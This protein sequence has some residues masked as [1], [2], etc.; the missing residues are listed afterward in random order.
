[1]LPEVAARKPPEYTLV[2]DGRSVVVSGQV[3][4]KPIR[5][6][7]IV[8]LAI[9]EG[10]RGLVLEGAARVFSQLSP[11]DW[12]EAHG[13]VSQRAGLPVIAVA[14]I[15]TVSSG[16][17]PYP[18]PLNPADVQN[19]DRL[20][21]LVVT[22]GQVIEIGSNFGGAYL[23]MGNYPNTLKVF[24]PNPPDVRQAFAGYAVGDTVRV[25]GIAYQYCPIPPHVD[26]FELLI[27][28]THDV[29]RVSG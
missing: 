24:L 1:T 29:A 13:R 7:E 18:L 14:K 3:S 26:Q 25:T 11:G 15:V 27:G 28:D 6:G 17:P 9:Q 20:G 2:N 21:Q 10:K 16:A 8:H 4:A 22:E 23:R 5:L 12:I 19:L